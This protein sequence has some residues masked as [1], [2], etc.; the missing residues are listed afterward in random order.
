L[1]PIC[2]SKET[3]IFFGSLLTQADNGHTG[4][5]FE[6]PGVQE[7]LELVR[8]GGVNCIVVKDFSRFSRNALESGYYIEQVFPLFGVRF[9]SVGDYFDSDDYK[10]STGG[11]DVAFKFLV[12]EHY[13]KDLSKK[14]KSPK[15]IGVRVF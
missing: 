5:D 8:C 9:I 11:L 3:D 4:T 12:N 6:R 2:M 15:L 14:P 1:L 13:S 7:M 10:D